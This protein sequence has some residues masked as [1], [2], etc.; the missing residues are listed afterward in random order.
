MDTKNR[1]KIGFALI[2]LLFVG[3]FAACLYGI[4]KIQYIDG[5]TWG[6]IGTTIKSLNKPRRIEPLRGTIYCYNSKGEKEILAASMKVYKIFF[7]GQQLHIIEKDLSQKHR[8]SPKAERWKFNRTD[9]INKLSESLSAYLGD[10]PPSYYRAR[11]NEAYA[12]KK[13]VLLTRRYVD[14]LQR[15][16]LMKMPLFNTGRGKYT[17][18]MVSE[19][20][21]RRVHPYG[22][23]ALRTI[24]DLFADKS[25]TTSGR[26]GIELQFDS[27]LRGID[28]ISNPIKISRSK[29]VYYD[30]KKAIDGADVTLTLNIEMQEITHSCLLRQA[31]ALGIERGCAILMEVAT[32]EI[33]AISNLYYSPS[34][35]FEGGNMA[36]AD[37]NP[38][39][40]TFKTLS[41]LVAL[42]RGIVEPNTIV[43]SYNK[44][45]PRVTDHNPNPSWSALTVSDVLAFS[46][47]VGTSNIIG[48]AYENRPMD[49]VADIRKTG[50]NE[51]F[52]IQLPGATGF[53]IGPMK[54][55]NVKDTIN[56]TDLPTLSFGYQTAVP[57]IYMLRFYNAIAN[58]GK[59]IDPFI[60]K[61]ISDNGTTKRFHAKTAS[62]PIASNKTIAQLQD[63][64]RSVVEKKGGTAYSCRSS[65]VSFAGKTGTA[66]FFTEGHTTDQVSF[67]GYFPADH[68]LYS[69]IVVMQRPN[70]W[71]SQSG[72]VFRNIAEQVMFVHNSG[73][74]ARL[75][76]SIKYLPT[77]VKRGR[78][79]VM[80]YLFRRLDVD[81]DILGYEW[82]IA[83]NDSNRIRTVELETIQNLV[84]NVVG[85]GA[86][87]AIYLLERNGLRT[88]LVGRGTVRQQSVAAGTRIVKGQTVGL[89]L[90]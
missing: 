69:C 67:C 86:K 2:Y 80:K 4:I 43:D 58:G 7:N 54:Y 47:N 76:D 9:S 22:G 66:V 87:D 1:I 68:P 39:G 13:K 48:E 29:T 64:L 21:N 49:F 45:Y 46:S 34:G 32:G 8:K 82:V 18:C 44:R 81:A 88:R 33:K 74:K 14:Y 6:D 25:R 16:E 10:A 57:P 38:P 53:K 30:D 89:T 23:M 41:L 26:F 36:I 31:Q 70:I 77:A 3:L 11:I 73:T 85:M 65:R 37:L 27:L 56:R 19:E 20:V 59:L 75:Q 24:G 83:R 60:V 12:K 28:G 51:P 35:Y 55:W 52:D 61:E 42:E 5:N 72:E 90:E 84:P 15:K 71:G 40:S 79:D 17:D 50:V 62:R 63:M 78:S